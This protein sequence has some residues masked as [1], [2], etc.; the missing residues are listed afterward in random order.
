MTVENK[1]KIQLWVLCHKLSD[2]STINQLIKN[3]VSGKLVRCLFPIIK[4]F[5]GPNP[6][7]HVRDSF[8]ELLVINGF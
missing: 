6:L 2:V 3:M 7:Q 5:Q 4:M 1:R 8:Y